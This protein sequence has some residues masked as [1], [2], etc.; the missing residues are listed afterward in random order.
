[1]TNRSTLSAPIGNKQPNRPEDLQLV[2]Q[3]LNNFIVNG[4]LPGFSALAISSTWDESVSRVLRAVERKY[5]YG[6]ADP[7]NKLENEDTLFKFLINTDLTQKNIGSSLSNEA[8]KLAAAMVPGGSDWIRRT[9][10]KVT[11]IV[12]GKQVIKKTLKSE[13]IKGNIRIYLPL[14]LTALSAQQLND[15]DM[16]MMALGTIRAEASAFKPVDEGISK[17]NTTPKGTPGRHPF[18]KYDHR[19][20]D[21]GNREDGDGALFKGR[22]FVQLTGKSNYT[23]IGSK[24]G[25][26]LLNNPDLAN[27]PE[28]AAK[29]LAQFLKIQE[30]SIREALAS[31]NL[32]SARKR[33]NG[34]SHGLAEFIQ[35]FSAGRK[36]LGFAIPAAVKAK[37]KVIQKKTQ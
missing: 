34:G 35:A 14:I 17:Y 12:N 2:R 24:I 27:E 23:S 33:V 30:S 6:N 29:I 28:I 15:T 22:G 9:T 3:L 20:S 31:N 37:T 18:D 25:V 19:T 4:A 16:L 8:Y 11:E 32:A 1:M 5:F 21:L 7:N 36:Y 13:E 26:D 10:V